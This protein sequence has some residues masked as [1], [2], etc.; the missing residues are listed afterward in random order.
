MSK[1][2]YEILEVARSA[3]TQTIRNAAQNKLNVLKNRYATL[4]SGQQ[5]QEKLKLKQTLEEIKTAY[6]VLSN[7]HQRKSYDRELGS[8]THIA[9]S[10]PTNVA[11]TAKIA[12]APAHNPYATPQASLKTS[13]NS[14]DVKY[15]GFWRRFFAMIVDG[16]ICGILIWIISVILVFFFGGNFIY[17]GL[18]FLNL[19]VQWLYFTLSESSE[20]QSTIGKRLLGLKVV[21]L[22]GE[23]ISFLRATGRYF[24]KILSAIILFLGFIMVAFTQRKQG[25]H[26]ILAGTLIIRV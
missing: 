1:N 6:T 19:L 4:P 13:F 2:Y 7:E 16:I 26:D 5:A 15:G 23:R 17:S 14:S 22:A 8:I 20:K 9:K 24:S 10:Q 11:S 18:E 21:D 3:D 12:T 25:L